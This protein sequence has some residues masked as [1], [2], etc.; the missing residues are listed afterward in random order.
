MSSIKKAIEPIIDKLGFVLVK[1]NLLEE[2]KTLQ[3]IVD[4]KNNKF[5][6]TNDCAKISKNISV[7][8]DVNDVISENYF[9]EVSSPGIDRP[10]INIDDWRRFIGHDAEVNVKV[11]IKGRLYF[12]GMIKNYKDNVITFAD[13]E[14]GEILLQNSNIDNAKLLLTEKLINFSKNKL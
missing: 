9:L 14:L 11:S 6:T 10:L 13:N 7:I 12:C 3:I 8:L 1:L 5:I 2:E 4:S